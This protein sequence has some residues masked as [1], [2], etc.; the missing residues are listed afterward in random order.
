M[1]ALSAEAE[2]ES[3]AADATKKQQQPAVIHYD[4]GSRVYVFPS[5][6]YIVADS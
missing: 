5:R 6:A 4:V 2:E 1:T 3:Q